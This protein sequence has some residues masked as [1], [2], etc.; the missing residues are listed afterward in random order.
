[1]KIKQ[2]PE[3]FI[4]EEVSSRPLKESGPYQVFLMEKK[5]L[6]TFGA[7]RIIGSEFRVPS[8]EIGLAGLKDKHALTRQFVSFPSK[9][10]IPE[11]WS[12]QSIKLK[13]VGFT[14]QPILLGDID[15]NRFTI[16]VR[17]VKEFEV[18]K[19]RGTAMEVLSY[20]VPN[21]FDSQRF[22]SLRG[23]QSYIAK[24]LVKGDWEGAIKTVLT[25]A[26]RHDPAQVRHCREHIK[27]AWGRWDECMQACS[28]TQKARREKR[29]IVFIKENPK[30]FKSA[31]LLVEREL[32]KMY[33]AAYQS[34]LWNET[35]KVLLNRVH[36]PLK[37]K[38][39]KYEAGRLLFPLGIPPDVAVSLRQIGIPL[40]NPDT[41]FS[42]E[43]VKFAS[44]KVV[45]DEALFL[46]KL[47]IDGPDYL[48][49][50][51]GER[52]MWVIPKPVSAPSVSIDERNA[53]P[54][55]KFKKVEISFEL[56]AGSYATVIL[57]AIGVEKRG[58]R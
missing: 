50:R 22:G 13:R 5:G 25:S 3:D 6:D 48:Q 24:L 35:V 1:M 9:Y 43:D 32:Q 23:T 29:I 7:K 33:V 27:S 44:L 34:Y 16:V 10:K 19:V 54:Q 47:K 11:E 51:Q 45:K 46:D 57:K 14:D 58:R 18:E 2:S 38:Q 21:Y 49:F 39:V 15:A 28:G 8:N 42:R 56:P 26:T 37:L 40:L 17:E 30:D 31:F 20:G 41:Q 52:K 55:Y 53:T 12:Q 36:P 4:V